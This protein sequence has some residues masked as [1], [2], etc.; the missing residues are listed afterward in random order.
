MKRW[1]RRFF[2]GTATV[3]T[4][5]AA[6]GGAPPMTLSVTTLLNAGRLRQAGYA[7]QG[8]RVGVISGGVTHYAVLAKAGILPANV[9][10]YG[11]G[12]G[13]GDEGDWMM[14]I[15]HAIA[16]R[17]RLAFCPGGAESVTVSCAQTLITRFHARI[18]VDDIN[19]QPVFFRPSPKVI[20]YDRLR[21]A[22]PRVLFFT[23][24]GNNGGGYYQG[25]GTP[26]SLTLNGQAYFAQDF[27]RALQRPSNPYDAFI[28]P[29]GAGARIVLG[30]NATPG[31]GGR[32]RPDNPKIT[33]ALVA[34][35]GT[36]LAARTSRCPTMA[37][38]YVNRDARPVSARIA[39]LAS[40]PGA[41]RALAFKLVAIHMGAARGIGPYPLRYATAGGAGNSAVPP[42]MQAVAA[43]DPHTRYRGHFLS[44]AF[45]NAGPQRQDYVWAEGRFTRLPQP[46]FFRQPTFS[47]PDRTR[48]AVVPGAAAP[49]Y[50]WRPFLGDSAAAPAAG[51]AAALLLSARVP[52]SR[53]NTLLRETAR[54]QT[55]QAGWSPRFG[56]GLADVDAAAVKG[57]ILPPAPAAPETTPPSPR[58]FHPTPDFLRARREALAAR[59]GDA[60]AL[61]SLKR[62]AARGDVNAQ[63]WLGAYQHW[64][65]N[66]PAAARWLWRA[67]QAGQ[68][69]AQSMLGSSF[70]HGWGLPRDRRAAYAWWRRAARAG[71]PSALYNLGLA[72]ATGRGASYAPALAYAL[73][74]AAQMRGLHRPAANTLLTRLGARLNR[75]ERTAAAARAAAIAARPE[76]LTALSPS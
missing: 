44:E 64:Q 11:Q 45:A 10:F 59:A 7:G 70:N 56:A 32:C 66:Y 71:A 76:Q 21:A 15:V 14:Q 33:L 72:Y 48:V 3:M 22:H 8:V 51:G 65:K 9:A 28:M 50:R 26:V 41:I 40:S 12:P 17:A 38:R 29:P 19:P 34:P 25:A 43:V 37:V 63:T 52:A 57:G 1:M 73:I 42:G 36:V 30:T 74:R 4:C 6:M 23:G 75:R 54:S 47:V 61:V 5:S 18:I 67:A 20:G 68:P 35:G 53:V 69:V 60:Q 24:A 62:A 46:V 55:G 58:R 31:S 49:G 27:G 2:L 39:I 13:Q 16:P